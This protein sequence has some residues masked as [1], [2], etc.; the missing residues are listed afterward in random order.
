MVPIFV[1]WNKFVQNWKTQKNW[2]LKT[3]LCRKKNANFLLLPKQPNLPKINDR[4]YRL[5]WK[6]S[7]NAKVAWQLTVKICW[8]TKGISD[9][10]METI[11]MFRF[12]ETMSMFQFIEIMWMFRFIEIKSMF[13]FIETLP[14]FR[15]IETMPM[16]RFIGDHVNVSIYR[17]HANVSIYRDHVN[18]LIYQDHVNVSIYRDQVNV[19]IYRNHLSGIE[20]KST[21]FSKK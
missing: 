20:P 15:F 19:S 12:I 4:F 16:F 10:F 13:R 5:F 2:C 3:P 11:S 6:G 1:F 8:L 9:Q 17:D 21:Q 14:M 18:V 7:N